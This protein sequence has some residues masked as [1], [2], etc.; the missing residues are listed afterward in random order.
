MDSLSAC[1]AN[2]CDEEASSMIPAD[3]VHDDMHG[4]HAVIFRL[5]RVQRYPV[6]LR[7]RA[8]IQLAGSVPETDTTE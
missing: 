2:P 3:R 6:C 5:S 1:G 7:V 4:L 8:D